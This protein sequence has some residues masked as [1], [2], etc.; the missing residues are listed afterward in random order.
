MWV[1]NETSRYTEDGFGGNLAV[2]CLLQQNVYQMA[3][4]MTMLY[5]NCKPPN[6]LEIKYPRRT[7]EEKKKR[8]Q[9]KASAF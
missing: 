4:I 7:C 5:E 3:M 9:I 2:P 1:F 6:P 8:N